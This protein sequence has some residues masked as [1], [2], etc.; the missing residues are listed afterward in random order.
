VTFTFIALCVSAMKTFAVIF[1]MTLILIAAVVDDVSAYR[2]WLTRLVPDRW[3]PGWGAG[4]YSCCRW[5]L[6]L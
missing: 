6:F 1:L 4:S 2:R 5:Y 3:E